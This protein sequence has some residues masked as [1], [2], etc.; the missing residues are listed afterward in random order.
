MTVSIE[1]SAKLF[2]HEQGQVLAYLDHFYLDDQVVLTA[3]ELSVDELNA[4]L[5]QQILPAPSYVLR[6]GHLSSVV[7][8]DL[9][10]M[11]MPDTRYF[12]RAL[13]PAM[14]RRVSTVQR[15][16]N[17][18]ALAEIE[19]NFRAECEDALRTWHIS[20]DDQH[21]PLQDCFDQDGGVDVEGLQKRL[22]DFWRYYQQGVFGLC[23]SDPSSIAAI[24]EKELLQEALTQLMDSD[25]KEHRDIH[26]V[27][28]LQQR[29]AKACM[30]F[31]AIEF[32]RSSRCRLLTLRH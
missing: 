29:Y 11:P 12:H 1:T 14:Q 30:P 6:S 9:I 23:V 32:P 31:T 27:Q 10:A 13:V 2:D 17:A 8:G 21:W 24:V 16:G 7:F 26:Q 25:A 5:D 3:L 20:T 28:T 4:L 22:D 18:I 15:L 19:Q